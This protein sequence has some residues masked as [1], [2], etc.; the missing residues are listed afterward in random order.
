MQLELIKL[1]LLFIDSDV[2]ADFSFNLL[3]TFI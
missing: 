2:N 3:V 1:N